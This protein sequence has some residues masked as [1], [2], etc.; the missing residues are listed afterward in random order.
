MMPD[1]LVMLAAGALKTRQDGSMLLLSKI[2][3]SHTS[4]MVCF[5]LQM[6]S[7]FAAVSFPVSQLYNMCD[8]D[9]KIEVF[10]EF[11]W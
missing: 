11:E 3:E 4:A 9:A 7:C 1:D 10:S 2:S 6:L 8:R 5:S